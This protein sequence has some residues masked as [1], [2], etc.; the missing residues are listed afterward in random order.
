[1]RNFEY[2]FHLFDPDYTSPQQR[3][4]PLNPN[5][6]GQAYHAVP[7]ED[8]GTYTQLQDLSPEMKTFYDKNLIRLAEPELVHDQFGQKRPIPGGNGK[9]I[10][11]RKFNALPAVPSDRVLVEGI[12]P[13]GQNYGVTA[14]T[15]TV[16]QYG[17]YITLSD[18]LNLTAYDNQMQEVMKILASQAGQVSDKVTRDILV[19]GTNVSYAGAATGRVDDTGVVGLTASDILTIEDIKKAVRKLKRVNA[20]P[21]N[22]SYVAIVH[23]DIAYDLMNDSEWIDANQYA[24]ST[25]IFNGE[26][27]KMYGVRFVETTMAKIWVTTGGLPVYATLVLAENAFGVTSINN[28]GIETIVKQLGSGGTADPL[29]QRS[30]CG[31]KLQK[32]AKILEESYMVR[33][34]SAASF[35]SAAEA[36]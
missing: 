21:I 26:I 24:G 29:N 2:D 6:T 15:A 19:T 31:Y 1:M 17:G 12:T 8:A 10:E 32:V 34:E 30:T 22:G 36:N 35:G 7:A 11:F 23:P 33:I 16:V 9:T 14:I 3:Y 4:T 13:N 25:A 27:G 5:Y 18:M 20:K 28:G